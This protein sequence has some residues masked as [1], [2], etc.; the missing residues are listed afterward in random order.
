MIS[1]TICLPMATTSIPASIAINTFLVLNATAMV[2]K[3][4]VN[5]TI[6]SEKKPGAARDMSIVP[7]RAVKAL[8]MRP[9]VGKYPARSN[10]PARIK[11]VASEASPIA[12]KAFSEVKEIK[13]SPFVV[14]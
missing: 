8:P 6:P 14:L 7:G 12:R 13:L 4:P 9:P 3:P 2:I 10:P 11:Y 1:Y 5:P